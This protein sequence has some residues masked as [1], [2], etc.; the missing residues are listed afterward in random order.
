[1]SDPARRSIGEGIRTY[2]GAFALVVLSTLAGLW[3]APRWGSGAVDLLYLPAVLAAAVLWGLGP[4]IFAGIAAALAYNFFFTEPIHTLRIDRV[5]DIV[6]VTV[7]FIVAVVTSRL[8]SGIRSQA[9]IAEAHAARN[10]T[11]AGFA[12]RLLSSSGEEEIARTACEELRQVFDCNAVLATGIPA[13]RVLGAAPEGNRLTTSDLAAAALTIETGEAAGRGTSHAQPAE[14]LFHAVRSGDQV[15]AAMGLARDDGTPPVEPDQLPLMF[16]LLDQ[17]ALALERARLE[18]EAREFASVRERDRARATLLASIASDVRPH[19]SAITEAA[20]AQRREGSSDR[21]FVSTVESEASKL[22]RYVSNLAGA[23][24]ES[25]RQ[26]IET[27]DVSIDL[28]R[29]KVSRNGQE[30]HLTPKEYAILAELAKHRGQVLTHAH[31][32]RTAW[33]PAQEA[34]TEYLRVAVRALR[35]KLERDPA[36]PRLIVN[37]PAVGYRLAG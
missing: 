34:Q 33:G 30:V 19:L 23:E 4:A 28:F 9:Q 29:R 31:L 16:G 37:E 11:I 3:I 35:Q 27:G 25:D 13:P 32:L 17:V 26:P 18:R 8:A 20:R 21:A 14:W 22:E 2:A 24:S 12:R 36:R 7:L 6:T 5:T 1:V 10:A 15:L